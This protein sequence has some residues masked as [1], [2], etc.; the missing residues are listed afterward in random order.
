MNDTI[1]MLREEGYPLKIKGNGGFIAV[2]YG[3][4]PLLDGEYEAIYMYPGGECVHCLEEINRF[5][6]V[7]EK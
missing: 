3:I 6:E 1:K 4:Q 5:F 7:I 2:L